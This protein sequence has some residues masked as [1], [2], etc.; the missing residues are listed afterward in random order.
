MFLDVIEEIRIESIL[1][2]NSRNL[3][4]ASS[5]TSSSSSMI[6]IIKP[7]CRVS[8]NKT[9]STQWRSCLYNAMTTLLLQLAVRGRRSSPSP[10]PSTS[11]KEII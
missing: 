10:S 8:P 9:V 4:A 2:Q 3:G 7:P 11:T 5:S 6:K 1:K